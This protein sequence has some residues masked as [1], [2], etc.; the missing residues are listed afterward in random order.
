MG[1]LRKK[2]QSLSTRCLSSVRRL[3]MLAAVV[4][5]IIQGCQTLRQHL[6]PEPKPKDL[7]I[8]GDGTIDVRPARAKLSVGGSLRWTLHPE[9]RL[10]AEAILRQLSASS[11]M[12]GDWVR[13]LIQSYLPESI[14]VSTVIA[15]DVGLPE[16]LKVDPDRDLILVDAA[17]PLFDG[18][19]GVLVAYARHTMVRLAFD[20]LFSRSIAESPSKAR[21]NWLLARIARDGMVRYITQQGEFSRPE[22]LLNSSEQRYLYYDVWEDPWTP[23]AENF[24][25]L[26]DELQEA[27]ALA[28]GRGWEKIAADLHK[29]NQKSD[30]FARV[31]SYMAKSIEESLGR[32]IL[33]GALAQ[34][35]RAF[36]DAYQSTRPGALMTF[37][38]PLDTPATPGSVAH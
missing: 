4:C 33:V 23:Y 1:S 15:I 32:S 21:D 10:R 22:P 24:F 5:P 9:S 29:L 36:Y 14:P 28:N 12:F 7:G 31:G 34:G 37:R 8:Y 20:R 30:L 38:L 27:T 17:A 35:P 13:P 11:E 26:D 6:H 2:Q 18:K 16:A 25:V 19:A 3:V